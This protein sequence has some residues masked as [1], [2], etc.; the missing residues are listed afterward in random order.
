M[1]LK[2]KHDGTEGIRQQIADA[3]RRYAQEVLHIVGSATVA[4][5]QALSRFQRLRAP[6]A[7]QPD[8]SA[9]KRMGGTK[10]VA[11]PVPGCKNTGVRR[12]MNFCHEHATLPRRQ[13]LRLRAAQ[14]SSGR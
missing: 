6:E 3:A 1:A 8:V 9:R 10:P 11:C 12:H 14:R 13:R 7:R 2:P 5:L 4:Q